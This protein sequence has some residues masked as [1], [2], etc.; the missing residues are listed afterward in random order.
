MSIN[1]PF[2]IA[3]V[4]GDHDF[5]GLKSPF[6]SQSDREGKVQEIL[7]CAILE[8]HAH[9]ALAAFSLPP[10]R[11]KFT[12]RATKGTA[13]QPGVWAQKLK[14]SRRKRHRFETDDCSQRERER[15]RCLSAFLLPQ[16]SSTTHS[17]RASPSHF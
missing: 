4:V 9:G 1:C 13:L 15:E 5:K 6:A 16:A 12:Q 3:K 7:L 11:P 10:P 17:Q 8:R 14:D 2:R